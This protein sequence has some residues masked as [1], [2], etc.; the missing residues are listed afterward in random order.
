MFLW[1]LT[2][3][4]IKLTNEVPWLPGFPWIIEVEKLLSF[5]TC[6]W[7]WTEVWNALLGDGS[8]VKSNSD[9]AWVELVC[10]ISGSMSIRF[11]AGL[12]A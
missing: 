9:V 4:Y 10:L 8:L 11:P 5:D 1:V 2:G 6:G 7:F 3:A 12:G